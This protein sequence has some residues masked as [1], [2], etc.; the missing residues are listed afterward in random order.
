MD[1]LIR[2]SRIW[3]SKRVVV[4]KISNLQSTIKDDIYN[5]ILEHYH[6]FYIKRLV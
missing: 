6:T 1:I 2:S 5:L 4:V 3:D